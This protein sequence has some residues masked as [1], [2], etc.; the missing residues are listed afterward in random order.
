LGQANGEKATAQG[1]I[2]ADLSITHTIQPS[3]LIASFRKRK[4]LF[5]GIKKSSSTF[6]PFLISIF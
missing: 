5:P 1:Q 6:N 3:P 4:I 2:K